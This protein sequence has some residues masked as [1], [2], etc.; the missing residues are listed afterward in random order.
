MKTIHSPACRQK[1][2][3]WWRQPFD[4]VYHRLAS[5]AYDHTDAEISDLLLTI[6]DEDP[7]DSDAVQAARELWPLLLLREPLHTPEE[8]S[9]ELD[10]VARDYALLKMRTEALAAK[11]RALEP[12]SERFDRYP[13]EDP[14]FGSL[15]IDRTV[16]G[17]QSAAR[18][19]GG[20]AAESLAEAREDA[21]KLRVYGET[22]PAVTA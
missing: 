21:A 17:L 3:E 4:S 22:A 14:E 16:R 11:Y 9:D 1:I 8:L 13:H 7:A 20:Y 5:F 10:S 12:W 19:L 15:N 18:S 6:F 2:S